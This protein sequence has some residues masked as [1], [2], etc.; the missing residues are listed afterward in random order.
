VIVGT[1]QPLYWIVQDAQN[2]ST[3]T[4]WKSTGE[5]YKQL[6]TKWQGAAKAAPSAA[7]KL[8][9][10]F[11]A[12]RKSF[13][14]ARE[15]HFDNL[16]K[17]Q[18]VAAAEKQRIINRAESLTNSSDLR[19]ASEEMKKLLDEWKQAGRCERAEEDRL[20]ARF[21]RARKQLNERRSREFEK[22]KAEWTANKAE[23]ERIVSQAEGL[24]GSNDLKSA[25]EKMR[26]LGD[27]WKKVG[28]CDKADNEKLWQRF[29]AARTRLNDRKHRQFEERKREWERNRAAKEQIV[30][31][32]ESLSSATDL[33]AAGNE[34]RTLT[35]R[36]KQVGQCDKADNEQLWARL[37]AA[38]TKLHERKQQDFENRKAE[39]RRKAYEY[40]SRLEAQ[41]SNVEMALYRAQD[42]YSRA[43]SARSPSMQN[44]NWM[45]I[46]NS[47]QRRQS[48]ARD[49]IA[50]IQN[51]RSEIISKLMSAR[52]QAASL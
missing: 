6:L 17:N 34:M 35:D 2:L 49:R 10:K 20:W 31:R 19:A 12:A 28:Q 8:W 14:D 42:S 41:L 38:K 24:A 47:Q 22:R 46:V 33:T 52:S 11:D 27:Q 37:N 21:D 25:S 51:R 30:A 39:R 36:W 16:K 7:N 23:K 9:P 1:D 15:Q 26:T 50:S 43:L 29:N 48:D 13:F 44:P 5:Q 40:V 18:F 3:S 32:A 4:D 45:S